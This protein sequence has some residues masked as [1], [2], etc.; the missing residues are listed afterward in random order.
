MWSLS[1]VLMPTV[2]VDKRDGQYVPAKDTSLRPT[3]RLQ[4]AAGPPEARSDG[5]GSA[6]EARPSPR[7]DA[8]EGQ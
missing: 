2:C 7:H 5:T 4:S 1:A 8:S 3:D 6:F